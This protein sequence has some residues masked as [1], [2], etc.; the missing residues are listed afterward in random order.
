LSR[1]SFAASSPAN[2]HPGFFG[3]QIGNLNQEPAIDVR[4]L[5]NLFY[6]HA[7]TE[8]IAHV[9]DSLGARLRQLSHQLSAIAC[10]VA[11]ELFI[12]TGGSGL[13]TA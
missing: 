9:P 10:P 13:Q 4:G 2:P 6:A 3:N 1:R 5:E 11:C 12:Q 8:G 7:E